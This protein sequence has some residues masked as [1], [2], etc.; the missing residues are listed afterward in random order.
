MKGTLI[1]V[2]CVF[3]EKNIYLYIIILTLPSDSSFW[4]DGSLPLFEE[5]KK[6]SEVA[7]ELKGWNFRDW[8]LLFRRLYFLRHKRQHFVK[9]S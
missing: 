4:Y 7:D 5:L 1:I 6:L 2:K 3:S 9:K 8:R